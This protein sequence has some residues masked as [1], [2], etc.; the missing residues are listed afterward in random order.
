MMLTRPS[1]PKSQAEIMSTWGADSDQV[2]VSISCATY[3]HEQYIGDA[4]NGFLNQKTD[5]PFEVIVYDDCSSDRTAEIIKRYWGKYPQIIKPIFATE[6][7]YSQGVRVNPEIIFPHAKGRYIALCE[8]DDFWID[9]VKLQ[10]QKDFLDAN[11]EYVVCYTDIQSFDENGLVD[12]DFGG[13]RRDVTKKDLQCGVSLFTLT[14][15]FRNILGEWPRELC[16]VKYGDIAIWSQLGDYGKGAYLRDVRP[17]FYRVHNGGV[18]SMTS[19]IVQNRMR[20]ETMMS[21]YSFRIKKGDFTLAEKNLEDVVMLALKGLGWRL[22][23]V[24]VKRLFLASTR[25]FVRMVR[26]G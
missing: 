19:R 9:D 25:R 23:S 21:L 10:R 12:K 4:L 11:P 5:F 7:Q 2:V 24:L 15:C 13:A 17:S 18:H 26:R 6:N 1:E 14:T 16:N 3:N 22:V 8:G 20:L